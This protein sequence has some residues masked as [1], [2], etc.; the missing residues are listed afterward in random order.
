MPEL[1]EVEN[2]VRGLQPLLA[3]QP[4]VSRVVLRRKDLRVPFTSGL[5]KKLDGA[6]L[7]SVQRRAKFI[8]FETEK[9]WLINH[10]GMTGSW[11]EQKDLQKHDHAILEFDSGLKLVFNDPRR[12]GLLILEDKER[13]NKNKWLKALGPEPFAE[14]FGGEWLFERIR[15]RQSPIKNVIMDQH[16]VVG[17]GN[18]YASEVLFLSGIKPKRLA[19]RIKRVEAEKLAVAIRD[20]LTKAIE[21]GGSTIRSYTNANGESGS[22]Q[23]LLQVYERDGE[24]CVTCGSAIRSAFLN[25]RSTYWCSSCQK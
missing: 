22:F 9:Y 4:T 11:R 5:A 15:K 20:V 21:H 1:P 19:S 3:D 8:L 6:K 10:L 17:V 24:K 2:V 23:E 12:F 25:G 18:I 16:L 13:L 14:E 7:L